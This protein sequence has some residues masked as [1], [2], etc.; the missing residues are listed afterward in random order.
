MAPKLLSATSGAQ[1]RGVRTQGVPIELP[2]GNI[3]HLRPVPPEKLAQEG[4][5]LDILTPLVARMLFAGADATAETIAQT[6]GM[7]AATEEGA[8][9]E[10]LKLAAGDLA[11]IER[12]CDLVC[13][14]AFVTP[15]IVD[16]P[17]AEDEISLEDLDLADKVHVFTLA[18]RGAAALQHFRYEPKATMEPV[19]DGEGQPQPAQ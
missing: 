4:E 2:S 6:L 16:D 8:T 13:K 18:L 17:Q 19:P 9:P 11:Q 5:I 15:L 1:W 3:A 7:V 14:A 12:V 10:T